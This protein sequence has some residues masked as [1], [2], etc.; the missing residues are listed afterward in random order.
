MHV[1]FCVGAF[2]LARA[3][4]CVRC[5]CVRRA[6]VFAGVGVDGRA[7]WRAFVRACGCALHVRDVAK[8]V[9]LKVAFAKNCCIQ[10]VAFLSAAKGFAQGFYQK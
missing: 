2:A 4:A 9:H 5:A 3:F 1:V 6:Q 7:R 10:L 8:P